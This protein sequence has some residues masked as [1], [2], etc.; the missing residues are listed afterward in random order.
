MLGTRQHEA[1]ELGLDA[2]ALAP[3]LAETGPVAV[4]DF[5]T[6]GLSEDA[7]A[8]PIEIGGVL[9]DPGRDRVTTF[10]RLLRPWGP[11]PRAVRALLSAASSRSPRTPR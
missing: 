8:E 2:G 10:V 7:A 4:V 11:V 5:E 6:T 1:S 3:W 9:L